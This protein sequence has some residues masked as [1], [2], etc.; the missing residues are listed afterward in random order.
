MCL[1]I[2]HLR[3][4]TNSYHLISAAIK[5]NNR[6][7]INHNLIITDNDGIGRSQVHCNLLDKTKKSHSFYLYT[8]YYFSNQALIA[9]S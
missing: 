6:R 1:L 2:H 5:G 4:T 8:Y 9:V 7:L 3:L